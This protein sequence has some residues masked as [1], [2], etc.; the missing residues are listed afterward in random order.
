MKTNINS[1]M[2]DKW[3]YVET[4][5]GSIRRYLVPKYNRPPL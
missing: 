3:V 2:S 5:V 1:F 4:S